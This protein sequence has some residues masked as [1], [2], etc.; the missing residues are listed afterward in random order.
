MRAFGQALILLSFVLLGFLTYSNTFQASFNFDD[1]G[2]IENNVHIRMTELSWQ[3]IADVFRGKSRTRP[4]PM[5]TFALNYYFGQ[6]N[7]VGYHL[8]NTLIHVI[9]AV[10]LYLFL[11]TTLGLFPTPLPNPSWVALFA[12][13]LWLVHPVQTQ[14]VT[15]IVQRINSMAALFYML[16]LL[17]YVRGRIAQ[18][19]RAGNPQSQSAPVAQQTPFPS[20]FLWFAGS[21]LA[22]LLAIG[23]KETS[24]TLPFFVF[25]YEWY[26]FQDLSWP[27]L[28][29]CLPWILCACA[30]AVLL[31]TV[32]VSI[33]AEILTDY[34]K[35]GFTLSERLLTESR[36]VVYY[37]SLLFCP[38]PSRLTLDYD[39]PLSYSLFDP[40][41]TLLSLCIL[42]GLLGLACWLAKRER[43]LSFCI[44]WFLGN[45][46]IESSV[47]P[48]DLVFEHRLYLPSMLVSLAM[49]VC[50]YRYVRPSQLATGLLC[51][52]VVVL[53][54]WTAQ[55]NEVWQ[56][57][58]SLWSDAVKKSPNK[59]RPYSNLGEALAGQGSLEGAV[60]HYRK[61]LQLQPDY[62]A[63]HNN[64]GQALVRQGATE[65]AIAHY[66]QA[67]RIKPRFA[68]AN[69]NLG[70]ALLRRGDIDEAI[71]FYRQALKVQ[72]EYPT[73]HNNLGN[74]LF[75]QGNLE[76]AIAHYREALRMQPDLVD[77]HNNLGVA[78]ANTGNPR[79]AIVHYHEALRMH[80]DFA[81]AHFN[82]GNALYRQGNLEE[83]ITH[84]RE[85]LRIKPDFANA[86][87][88][89]GVALARQGN[90]EEA[91]AHRHEAR[92]IRS[93]SSKLNAAP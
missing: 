26:F 51:V 91:E 50:L 8:V 39:F 73:A 87:D 32:H 17:L 64:L 31:A 7:V 33:Y 2:N 78:L 75:R 27:W 65:Q 70:N 58:V 83:A 40:P 36:V 15:Y 79:E 45:L 44:L 81:N 76:E 80:P 42:A 29:R 38:H 28:R 37:V 48:L 88:N 5:L 66:R 84:Y 34:Q 47:I 93:R 59:A 4:V 68:T 62:P 90:R 71:V 56:D 57:P 23:S 77:A 46:V 67:L 35:W 85:T 86:H 3:E 82:L 18:R 61:A 24:V 9:N 54:L 20:P 41:T 49:V 13:L 63:A 89:L 1:R 69:Y 16:C 14:S 22:G 55:R 92:R 25:L 19:Q 43:L 12:A 21:G 30:P 6:Y 53:S 52:A 74:A 11:R 10:L 60:A 72:P